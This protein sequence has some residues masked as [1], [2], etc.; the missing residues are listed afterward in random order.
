MVKVNNLL[1]KL[2]HERV[3][4]CCCGAGIGVNYQLVWFKSGRSLF[5]L[6][7]TGGNN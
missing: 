7:Q 4:L 3:L 5:S 2:K 1:R 6:K